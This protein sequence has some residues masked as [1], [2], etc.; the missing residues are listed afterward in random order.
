MNTFYLTLLP[1]LFIA[2]AK[3]ASC[4]IYQCLE[5]EAPGLDPKICAYKIMSIDFDE[6]VY[7]KPCGTLHFYITLS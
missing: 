3:S 7:V 5:N 6:K 4:P 1:F 2:L